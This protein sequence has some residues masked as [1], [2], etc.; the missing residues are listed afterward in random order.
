MRA[1]FLVC[2]LLGCCVL[3]ALGNAAI[4]EERESEVNFVLDVL[5]QQLFSVIEELEAEEAKQALEIADLRSGSIKSELAAVEYDILHKTL[6]RNIAACESVQGNQRC[7]AIQNQIE[8]IRDQFS[9]IASSNLLDCPT[10]PAC[11]VYDS[12]REIL[13]ESALRRMEQ[14]KVSSDKVSQ[15]LDS[16]KAGH[17]SMVAEHDEL[18]TKIALVETEI[19]QLIEELERS[20]RTNAMKARAIDDC[21][22]RS[23]AQANCEQEK[24]QLEEQSKALRS[25]IA[26]KRDMETSSCLAKNGKKESL[27]NVRRPSKKEISKQLRYI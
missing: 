20:T 9:A 18:I 14:S 27:E 23:V 3:S 17:Q 19:N 24:K 7:E 11:P 25:C 16:C 21:E 5:R 6:E 15:H 12:I 22:K 8:R 13:L 10:D 4:S 26:Q 2:F 1:A